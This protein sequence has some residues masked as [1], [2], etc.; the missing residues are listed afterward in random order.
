MKRRQALQLIAITGLASPGK[1]QPAGNSAQSAENAPPTAQ[2]YRSKHFSDHEFAVI[3]RLADLIL[4]RDSTP[5]A[6]DAGVPEY[7]DLQVADMPEAKQVRLSGGVLWLDRYCRAEFGRPFLECSAGEQKTVLD[8]LAFREKV[9]RN[10][11]PA[12][13]FFKLVRELA[14]DGFY[15]SKLGFAEVGYKGNVFVRKFSGCTH[16]EHGTS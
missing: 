6:L 10:L 2:S 13:A 12:R 4:P 15:S 14:C 1:G 16:P 9:T 5:G 11:K 8:R 7:I 3:S